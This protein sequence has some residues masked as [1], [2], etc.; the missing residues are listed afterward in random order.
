MLGLFPGLNAIGGIQAS[1]KIAWEALTHASDYLSHAGER[2]WDAYLFCFDLDD[3]KVEWADERSLYATSK[4][5]AFLKSLKVRWPVHLVLVWHIGLLKLLPAF[6]FSNVRVALF[7]HGI[8]SWRR[9][10]W[11]T[12]ALLKK[13]D[14]FLSNSDYTWRRFLEA[15]PHYDA[16]P[17]STVHLGTASPLEN[18]NTDVP[19]AP[20]ALMISRLRKEE[21]YKGHCEMIKAWPSVLERIPDAELWIAGEGD[22]RRHLEHMAEQQGVSRQ[23]RFLGQISEDAKQELLT[24]ARCLALPSR[25]EGF[26]LVYLEA[27]RMARPCLV[28]TLDAGQEVVNTPEA[29]LAVN[30]AD[31]EALRSALCRL[32]TMSPEWQTWSE[33]AQRRYATNFTAR[34]FQQRLLAALAQLQEQTACVVSPV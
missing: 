27:M 9:Q 22:L 29:G 11:L 23:V 1:G 3:K 15:N 12:Q 24:R 25:G 16:Y 8:E 32:L 34:H 7:L 13:V 4:S 6:R 33:Q 14:C 28:S 31:T 19:A 2:E 18:Q 17:H 21:D 10:G 26:G 5:S 30:P 20:I